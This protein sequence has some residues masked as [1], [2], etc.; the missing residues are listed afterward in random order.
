ML[1]STGAAE[2]PLANVVDDQL[3][4][5]GQQTAL[6]TLLFS[7]KDLPIA[8]NPNKNHNPVALGLSLIDLDTKQV[9]ASPA[10]G[11]PITLYAGKQLGVRP[12]RTD[13]SVET[14]NTVDLTGRIVT[15]TENLSWNFY[16]TIDG[17]LDRAAA[18]E[19]IAGAGDPPDG[20]VRIQA[21]KAGA[22]GTFWAVVRDGRGGQAWTTHAWSA[23]LPP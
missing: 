3:D 20:L 14:Y 6:K 11:E 15:L 17:D 8:G 2:R 23:V 21:L 4:P 10:N 9:I 1:S 16:T 5:N 7:P 13:G 19:P 12:R 18:D 22:R